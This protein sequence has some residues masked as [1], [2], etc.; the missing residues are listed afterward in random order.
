MLI[1]AWRPASVAFHH[2]VG[3][4]TKAASSGMNA[5]AA[6]CGAAVRRVQ[7]QRSG[8]KEQKSQHDLHDGKL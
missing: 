4:A 1:V 2:E 7:P 6:G 3:K 8:N 5:G